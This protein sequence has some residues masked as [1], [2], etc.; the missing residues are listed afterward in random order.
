MLQGNS[1][2]CKATYRRLAFIPVIFT[3]EERAF[4]HLIILKSCRI[5]ALMAYTFSKSFV[6]SHLTPFHCLLYFL[7][8]SEIEN[9]AKIDQ[10]SLFFI[11]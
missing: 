5:S 3:G 7:C 9:F 1:K 10:V 6:A 2:V 4:I 11:Y 8:D